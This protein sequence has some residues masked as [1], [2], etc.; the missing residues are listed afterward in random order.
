[1]QQST[2]LSQGDWNT[3]TIDENLYSVTPILTLFWSGNGTLFTKPEAQFTYIKPVIGP[4]SSSTNQTANN[5]DKKSA[6]TLA[7]A[8]G[9]A[10]FIM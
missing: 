8:L 9:F 10:F 2:N 5:D 4:P 3:S 7:S 6:A 1:M